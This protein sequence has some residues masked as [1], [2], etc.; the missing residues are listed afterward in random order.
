MRVL[1][2]LALE[3]PPRYVAF[4]AAHLEPLREDAAGVVG[5]DDDAGR[6]YPEVLTDVALRWRW[7]ELLRRGLGRPDAADSYLRRAFVRRSR[8]WREDAAAWDAWSAVE[9]RVW[10]A[11]QVWTAPRPRP[12]RSSGATRIAA[13]VRPVS[14]DRAILAEAAVAWWHAYE[15][16]RRRRF[17]AA[18]VAVVLLIAFAW[19]LYPATA[20]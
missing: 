20:P 14:A 18:A 11:E 8:R 13:Y 6:L 1:R 17:I 4:V 10:T 12:V 7:L 2:A 16:H 15:A 3:P 9:I 19:R 5:G